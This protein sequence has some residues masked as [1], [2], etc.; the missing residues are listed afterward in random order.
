[1]PP[2]TLH[3]GPTPPGHAAALWLTTC[4]S[5]REKLSP[6]KERVYL[7]I[8]A[9]LFQIPQASVWTR[10]S[11]RGRN[12]QSNTC[13]TIALSVCLATCVEWVRVRARAGPLMHARLRAIVVCVRVS[14]CQ[15]E[16]F[17][18]EMGRWCRSQLLMTIVRRPPER[19]QAGATKWGRSLRTAAPAPLSPRWRPICFNNAA[20]KSC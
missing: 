14:V 1:M 10:A 9:S 17:I 19:K 4:Y 12:P 16:A 6:R 20:E 13:D 3:T 8:C 2:R 11:L 7:F 15:S 5:S 18:T